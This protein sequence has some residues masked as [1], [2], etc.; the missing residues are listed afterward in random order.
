MKRCKKCDKLVEMEGF[1]RSGRNKDGR[2]GACKDCR[3]KY[4]RDRKDAPDRKK[5]KYES[6]KRLREN[7]PEKHRAHQIVRRAIR[8]G[9]LVK[10]PCSCG[11]KEVMAHHEDYSKPLEV[12]WMCRKCHTDLHIERK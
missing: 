11:S 7:C 9:K 3:A 5:M 12:I 10:K 4:D 8:S 2:E 6:T 1:Y